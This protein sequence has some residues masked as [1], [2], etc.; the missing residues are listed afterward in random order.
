MIIASIVVISYLRIITRKIPRCPPSCD[1]ANPCTRDYCG[2]DTNYACAHF[3]LE[4]PQEGCSGEVECKSYACLEGS[5]RA[6]A[7]VPCCGN[8]VCEAGEG[9]E[10]CP[11]ECSIYFDDLLTMRVAVFKIGEFEEEKNERVAVFY[12]EN[13]FREELTLTGLK[14]YMDE[15]LIFE[16]DKAYFDGWNPFLHYESHGLVDFVGDEIKKSV[17]ESFEVVL[18]LTFNYRGKEL[19]FEGRMVGLVGEVVGVPVTDISVA[20]EKLN[21]TNS[22]EFVVDNTN[23]YLK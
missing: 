15:K 21:V 22:L 7:I 5:C 17:G 19:Y 9:I 10:N 2:A 18:T 14:V 8:G 3:A 12:L 1:D 4:G 16:K 11:A 6:E 23:V 20:L 13:F